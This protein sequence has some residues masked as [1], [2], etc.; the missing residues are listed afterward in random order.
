MSTVT[1]IQILKLYKDLLR[2][3]QNLTFTDKEYYSKRIR[4]EF[5]KNRSLET[6]SD[7]EFNFEVSFYL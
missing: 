4:R 7:I 2:Y 3:G 1:K 5:K 6:P